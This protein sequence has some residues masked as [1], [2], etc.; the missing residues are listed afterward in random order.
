MII[1]KQ[2]KNLTCKLSGIYKV[3]DRLH[4]YVPETYKYK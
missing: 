3:T 4:R 1:G 2:S